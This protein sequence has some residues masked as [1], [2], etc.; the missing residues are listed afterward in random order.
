M[1]ALSNSWARFTIGLAATLGLLS[2]T[3]PAMAAY[4]VEQEPNGTMTQANNI[5]HLF[6]TE[7]DPDIAFSKQFAHASIRGKGVATKFGRNFDFF[8]FN[9]DRPGGRGIF[10]IDRTRSFANISSNCRGRLDRCPVDTADRGFDTRLFLFD[11]TFSSVAFPSDDEFASLGALGSVANSP[12]G[13]GLS[14]DPFI[15]YVFQSAGTHYIGVQFEAL[16]GYR[17]QRGDYTLHVSVQPVPEPTAMIGLLGVGALG[18]MAKRRKGEK[19]VS[20]K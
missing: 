3:K 1:N 7:F 18:L 4:G 20:F 14:L 12:L 8:S 5:D 11:S 9:V 10:D 15:D 13:G 2:A 17:Q 6:S 16:D 19:V